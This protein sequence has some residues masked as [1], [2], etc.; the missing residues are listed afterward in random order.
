MLRLCLI[1]VLAVPCLPLA[2][3][4]SPEP[5][6]NN[7]TSDKRNSPPSPPQVAPG[8]PVITIDGFCEKEPLDHGNVGSS[9]PSHTCRTVITREQFEQLTAVL[10]PLAP[11][12]AKRQFAQDYPE[13]L[14][15]ARKAREIGLDKDPDFQET[16]KFT[17]LRTLSRGFVKR[18]QDQAQAI[19]DVEVEKSYKEHPELF[20]S[21]DLLRIY[22][23]KDKQQSS[24]PQ[25]KAD[26]GAGAVAMKAQAEKIRSQAAAGADFEKLQA[27]AYT[28]AGM[29]DPPDVNVGK[30]TRATLPL[31]YQSVVFGL[32]PGEV[33]Q[34]VSA[35]G[36]YH[37]FKVVS[38][39]LVPLSEAKAIL[40]ALRLKESIA[41]VKKDIKSQLNEEYFKALQ[42]ENTA[43]SGPPK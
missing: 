5:V 22:V 43:E 26:T 11:P 39:Q 42:S 28:A 19:S 3:A 15:F 37:I 36:G 1:W 7:Q 29:S 38:K 34:L 2:R 17:I 21:V 25:A 24:E 16:L 4:Q 41:A 14:L 8:T 23:P 6:Q 10:L 13:I 33:S 12:G 20:E 31:D 35:P 32:Q 30:E 18:L 27:A 40:Q 9:Q